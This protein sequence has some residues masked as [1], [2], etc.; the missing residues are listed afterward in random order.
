MPTGSPARLLASLN[1]PSVAAIQ[2]AAGTPFVV[3]ELVESEG[4]A[5]RLTRGNI[6]VPEA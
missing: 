3:L 4:P 5:A 2:E 6:P 1:H